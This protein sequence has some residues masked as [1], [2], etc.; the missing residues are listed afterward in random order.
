[1]I[2]LFDASSLLHVPPSIHGSKRERL[3]NKWN[4]RTISNYT[5]HVRVKWNCLQ[6]PWTYLWK[7]HTYR[8]VLPSSLPRH[9]QSV[10]PFAKN[11][12]K[13]SSSFKVKDLFLL[14]LPLWSLFPIKCC[15]Q[16]TRVKL[17]R[18]SLSLSRREDREVTST[19][20]SRENKSEWHNDASCFNCPFSL[21]L[22][23]CGSCLSK[24][25][26]MP[27]SCTK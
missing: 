1:M 6:S 16:L 21:G 19:L 23:Q 7:K 24:I 2:I 27:L 13:E 11:N 18:I 9:A 15:A 17:I 20:M 10:S 14:A 12:N 8:S 22:L 25:T 4:C 3:W 26:F 5:V